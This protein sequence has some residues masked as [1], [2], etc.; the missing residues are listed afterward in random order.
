MMEGRRGELLPGDVRGYVAGAASP[1]ER[2]TTPEIGATVRRA[3]AGG[4]GRS[5]EISG[6]VLSEGGDR[7]NR[8]EARGFDT[9]RPGLPPFRYDLI[10][11]A[12]LARLAQVHA[13]GC[14]THGERAWETD[15][16]TAAHHLNHAL[17]H[18]TNYMEGDTSDDHIGHALWRIAAIVHLEKSG[19]KDATRRCDRCRDLLPD[20]LVGR[21]EGR[22]DVR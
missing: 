3:G 1:A 6:V 4:Q 11:P 7:P 17:A 2:T 9:L 18:L 19:G 10:S 5:E 8:E 13:E 16:R 15:G 21:E 12:V 14:L 22:A 20:R